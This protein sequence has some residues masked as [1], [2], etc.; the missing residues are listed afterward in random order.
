VYFH[1][2]VATFYEFETLIAGFTAS[3]QTGMN[4]QMLWHGDPPAMRDEADDRR[5]IDGRVVSQHAVTAKRF[6]DVPPVQGAR[7]VTGPDD[8][9]F[10][11]GL[12]EEMPA[13]V[14]PRRS[15]EPRGKL[16]RGLRPAEHI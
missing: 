15:S 8:V 12:V 9:T 5:L 10:G 3:K 14:A 13:Q 1:N 4:G 16:A 2:P 7:P 11:V 6:Q